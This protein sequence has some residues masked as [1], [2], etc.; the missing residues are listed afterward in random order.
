LKNCISLIILHAHEDGGECA[1][2]ELEEK[3]NMKGI[4]DKKRFSLD[5]QEPN[6]PLHVLE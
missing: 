2:W 3:Q 6:Q 1:K 5:K 4:L